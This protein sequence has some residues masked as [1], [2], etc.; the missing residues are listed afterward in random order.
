MD[1]QEPEMVV[2]EPY[3]Y[4]NETSHMKRS[5]TSMKRSKITD[6]KNKLRRFSTQFVNFT[7]L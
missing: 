4:P 5:A 2:R 7:L 6:V 1:D 3:K